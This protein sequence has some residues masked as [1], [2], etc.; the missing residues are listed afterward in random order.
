MM[1]NSHI[2]FARSEEAEKAKLRA[3]ECA[4]RKTDLLELR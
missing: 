4:K 1:A 2:R 3:Q